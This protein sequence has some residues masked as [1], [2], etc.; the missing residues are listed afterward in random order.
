MNTAVSKFNSPTLPRTVLAKFASRTNN[1][2]IAMG[3]I[4]FLTAV[5]ASAQTVT[6]IHD[7]GSGSDGDN[8]QSGVIFDRH[9]NLF[10][11]AALG[12]TKG[13]GAAYELA[14]PARMG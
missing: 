12:G 1:I 2:V 5:G 7:F 6:T 8:P 13:D 10:G 11:T 3:L 4:I 14:P 9:G